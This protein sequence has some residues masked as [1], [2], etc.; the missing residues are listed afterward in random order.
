[1]VLFR[2][3]WKKGF[4]KNC[5]LIFRLN[6]VFRGSRVKIISGYFVKNADCPYCGANPQPTLYFKTDYYR[7]FSFVYK[8]VVV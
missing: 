3:F 4:K 7:E 1:M 6:H 5:A 8:D 2:F